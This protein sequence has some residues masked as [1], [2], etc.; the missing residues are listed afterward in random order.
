MSE[1]V[2]ISGSPF[3]VSSSDR[4]LKYVGKL[5]EERGYGVTYISVRD[6]EHEDL[7]LA[8]F[9]SPTVQRIAS[10]IKEA[11]GVLVSSPVY[12][13]AYSGVLKVF[14]DI[15]PQDILEGKPVLPIMTGGSRYHLLALEYALKPLL[16]TLKAHNL[17]GVYLVDSE[18]DKE[19][20]IPILDVDTL[21]RIKNQLDDFIEFIHKQNS[22]IP[23]HYTI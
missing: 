13:A 7:F 3:E 19:K 21:Q 6:V 1:I 9:N 14:I 23:S 11:K 16:A 10:Q 4:V 17:Q 22:L 8:N 12:K 5:L 15:L 2:L 20:D 18:I